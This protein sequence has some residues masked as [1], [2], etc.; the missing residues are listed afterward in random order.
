MVYTAN[1]YNDFRV[2]MGCK[3]T[4][5]IACNPPSLPQS[6]SIIATTASVTL[7]VFATSTYVAILNIQQVQL[8]P[9]ICW[10]NTRRVPQSHTLL[11]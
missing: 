5:I 1:Q 9:P 3:K 4:L 6:H 8:L 10:H 11:G 2:F 7:A